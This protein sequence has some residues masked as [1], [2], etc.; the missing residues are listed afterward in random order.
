MGCKQSSA[1]DIDCA[2]LYDELH[3]S[4]SE[5]R[6]LKSYFREFDP[7]GDDKISI[8][9][10][11]KTSRI[12]SSVLFKRILGSFDVSLRAKLSFC[13]YVCSL[14]CFLTLDLEEVN[15]YLFDLYDETHAG[16][17][18][19]AEIK[20]MM[21]DLHRKG[22]DSSAVQ[23][24][25]AEIGKT[26]EMTK[27]GFIEW[28]K[29]CPFLL[30]PAFVLMEKV[31]NAIMG[32]KFWKNITSRRIKAAVSEE[33]ELEKVHRI[34]TILSMSNFHNSLCQHLVL[35]QNETNVS[36]CQLNYASIS[37]DPNAR[38][39]VMNSPVDS[40]SQNGLPVD[41]ELPPGMLKLKPPNVFVRNISLTNSL[42][43]ECRSVASD[44]GSVISGAVTRGNSKVFSVSEIGLSEEEDPSEH[45]SS[46]GNEPRNM[47]SSGD[48]GDFE[49]S[50][51]RNQPMGGGFDFLEE[52]RKKLEEG[53]VGTH[54]SV[55]GRGQSCEG[56]ASYVSEEEEKVPDE[57]F[58]RDDVS[59]I[60]EESEL[61]YRPST[62]RTVLMNA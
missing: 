56:G 40:K 18:N 26:D 50:H 37:V 12:D 53:Y 15:G 17:L 41:E 23:S 7:F 27:E 29:K 39:G 8:A 33:D 35:T 52:V 10:Y 2:V 59:D 57:G 25:L 62:H 48:S 16:E 58:Y 45:L 19:R 24:A 11:I 31:R 55:V 60:S 5:V 32:D 13:E 3:L 61:K 44:L 6:R 38:G 4:T 43:D 20:Y 46:G 14:W 54:P 28:T 36:D 1:K 42:V 51:K 49:P 9:D 47:L 21:R 30:A 22:Y 34:R